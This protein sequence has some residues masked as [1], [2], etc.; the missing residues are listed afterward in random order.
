MANSRA[1]L[2]LAD[3]SNNSAQGVLSSQ[4][5]PQVE[6]GT[7][8]AGDIVQLTDYTA[9]IVADN[10][11]LVVMDMKHVARPEVNGNGKVLFKG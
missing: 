6:D 5:G 4:L 7:I 3:G 9:S 8:A 10:L 1:K 2:I 11:C